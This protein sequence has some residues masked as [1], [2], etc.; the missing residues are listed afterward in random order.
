MKE[1]DRR[2]RWEAEAGLRQFEPVADDEVIA[3]VDRAARHRAPEGR[4]DR[5]VPVWVIVDHLGFVRSGWATRQLR[6]QL[7]GLVAGGMLE[8]SRRHGRTCWTLTSAARKRLAAWQRAGKVPEL[9]E[10][11]QHR[12]WRMARTYAAENI[13]RLRAEVNA[14]LDRAASR[15]AP[16]RHARSELCSR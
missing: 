4:G 9:P 12:T 2:K 6:P 13:D 16:G 3:A 10:S 7:D 15:L 14:D 5:G 8:T 1:T 11:P